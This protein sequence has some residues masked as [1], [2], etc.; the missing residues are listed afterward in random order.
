M[1]NTTQFKTKEE[2]NKWMREYRKKNTQKF[3]DYQREYNRLWRKKNGYH[4][5][6]KW[7]K[8]NRI[9]VNAER[10][11]QNYI[12]NGKMKR[13]PCVICGKKNG[14]GHHPDYSKP[15]EVIFLCPLHHKEIHKKS[16]CA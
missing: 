14:L 8:N 2:Y 7:K 1:P 16:S 11:I 13:Q 4:T 15:I 12:K 6:Y 9:K 5:E 10:L 3:R